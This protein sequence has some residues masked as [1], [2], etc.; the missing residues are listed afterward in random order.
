MYIYFFMFFSQ[1]QFCQVSSLWDMYKGFKVARSTHPHSSHP[2]QLHAMSGELEIPWSGVYTPMPSQC[3][4]F[5]RRSTLEALRNCFVHLSID[6]Y[7]VLGETLDFSTGIEHTIQ[8]DNTESK[9]IIFCRDILLLCLVF[10][11]FLLKY[12]FFL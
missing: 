2:F 1:V 11:A 7:V 5:K 12:T 9:S 3:A 6:Y 8:R 10:V 4:H